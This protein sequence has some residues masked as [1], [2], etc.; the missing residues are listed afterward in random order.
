MKDAFEKGL[1]W[2]KRLPWY[3]KILG[4]VVLVGLAV[5]WVFSLVANSRTSPDLAE[6]D[7]YTTSKA[8][9]AL[10][11]LKERDD[12]VTTIIKKKKIDIATKLNQAGDIDA[13]TVERR[14]EINNAT[15]MEELDKLQK[16]WDL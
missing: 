4:C 10:D 8:D 16:E 13:T 12:E 3:W 7:K 2:W 5:L 6:V 14:E 15:S 1:A 9:A 11:A